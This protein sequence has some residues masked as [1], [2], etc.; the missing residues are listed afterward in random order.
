MVGSDG[1]ES[2]L[3]HG[4]FGVRISAKKRTDLEDMQTEFEAKPATCSADTWKVVRGSG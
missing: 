2:S 3:W 1:T 4:R